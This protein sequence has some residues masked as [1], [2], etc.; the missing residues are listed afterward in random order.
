MKNLSLEFITNIVNSLVGEMLLFFSIKD[1]LNVLAAH[2]IM[3]SVFK[4]QYTQRSVKKNTP[5]IIHWGS[6]FGVHRRMC[7]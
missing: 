7:L 4:K 1:Y 3:Y 6:I 2:V 5:C